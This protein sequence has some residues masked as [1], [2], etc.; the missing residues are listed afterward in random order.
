MSTGLEDS[1]SDNVAVPIGGAVPV[2]TILMY[3]G[4][5]DTTTIVKLGALGWLPCD[6]S[7]VKTHQYHDLFSVISYSHGGGGD[8]FHL[9]DLRGR[10]VRGVDAGAKRD[11]DV[12]ARV[13][14]APGG[15]KGDKVGSIQRDALRKHSHS[16]PNLPQT[17]HWA[18][19]E[20]HKYD[21]AQ[22]NGGSRDSEEAGGNETRPL[23]IALNYIIRYKKG[24]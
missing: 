22:W 15:N 1:G 10:F 11:P 14:P 20:A 7:Q 24:D 3:A 6:G 23:N 21:V 17:L 16:I 12:N 9:P 18:V 13:E 5:M 2:G 8:T 4:A 19:D